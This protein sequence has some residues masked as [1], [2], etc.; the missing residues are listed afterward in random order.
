MIASAA[1]ANA[2][3]VAQPETFVTTNN[4][5]NVVAQI[6]KAPVLL[7]KNLNG[8]FV[9]KLASEMDILANKTNSGPL[10][11][12]F[13]LLGRFE[14]EKACMVFTDDINS[15]EKFQAIAPGEG[16][17]PFAIVDKK[18]MLFLLVTHEVSHCMNSSPGDKA[19][20]KEIDKLMKNPEMSGYAGIG[21]LLSVAAG[22]VHADLT[23]ALLG[24]SKTGDWTL[25]SEVIVPLRTMMYDPAHATI[26]ALTDITQ[27]IDPK[28]LEGKPFE[29]IAALSNAIF[30]ENFVNQAGSLDPGSMGVKNI[31]R[32]WIASSNETSIIT[33][34]VKIFSDSQRNDILQAAHYIRGFA[35]AT[36]G[37]DQLNSRETSSFL[38]ALRSV[39]LESQIEKASSAKGGI[40]GEVASN[41]FISE[42][43]DRNG[44]A[45]AVLNQID[46]NPLRKTLNYYSDKHDISEWRKKFSSDTSISKLGAALPHLM[47]DAFAPAEDNSASLRIQEAEKRAATLISGAL[48]KDSL[49][50]HY[51][52]GRP[53]IDSTSAMEKTH[54]PMDREKEREPASL[55]R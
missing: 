41:S 4:F 13:A 24:A 12:N 11:N 31:L 3:A 21:Q 50:I 43:E 10:S 27:K 30:K 6:N 23:S 9:R 37:D 28:Q 49:P 53:E 45:D 7:S 51:G 35:T 26:N 14:N 32:E 19:W 20:P 22:E 36:L 54:P 34:H 15:N 52:M 25:L 38:L 33:P 2:H 29:D 46:S 17:E 39:S 42:N 47:E 1:T 8:D 40:Y 16:I 5:I 48:D 44:L 55:S 18:A